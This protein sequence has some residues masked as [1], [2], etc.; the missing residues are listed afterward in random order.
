MNTPPLSRSQL[1]LTRSLLLLALGFTCLVIWCCGKGRGRLC[2]MA[3]EST[4]WL[5]QSR[6]V[7]EAELL[8]G[9]QVALIPCA[10]I[11][12]HLVRQRLNAAA[13]LYRMG[14]VSHLIL[15][16]VVCSTSY[17]RPHA[18]RQMLIAR[19]V[20]EYAMREDPAGSSTYEA[21]QRAGQMAA[22][23]RLV[24]VTQELYAARLLILARGL[25]INAIACSLKYKAPSFSVVREEKECLCALLN[26][27]GLRRWAE[28]GEMHSESPADSRQQNT[29]RP[30]P[31][32]SCIKGHVLSSRSAWD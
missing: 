15:S 1:R 20:P 13:R 14:T 24:I 28:G 5:T 12:R 32:V 8:A 11:H 25:G 2:S 27:A 26:L 3:R 30:Q 6:I 18:V 21:I 31:S 19:G 7:Q 4:R 23:R 22:G 17:R 9:N 29:S 16:G 10:A